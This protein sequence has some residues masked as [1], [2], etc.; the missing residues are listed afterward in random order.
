MG[1]RSRSAADGT[2][3]E[4]FA[5]RAHVADDEAHAPRGKTAYVDDDQ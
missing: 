2:E 3:V 1:V 4:V 5:V